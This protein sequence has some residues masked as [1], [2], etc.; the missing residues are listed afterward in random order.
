MC[1]IRDFG[2]FEFIIVH[3]LHNIQ[4]LVCN[5]KPRMHMFILPFLLSIVKYRRKMDDTNTNE[6]TVTFL[7]FEV[8]KTLNSIITLKIP[9]SLL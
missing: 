1:T 6:F 8:K 7:R 9:C 5:G 2:I 3:G 4:D